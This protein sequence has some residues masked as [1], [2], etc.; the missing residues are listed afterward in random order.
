L[1]SLLFTLSL[2]IFGYDHYQHYF[3]NV[4][5]SVRI[6]DTARGF[7]SAGLFKR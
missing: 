4:V 7:V 6:D 1:L 5:G 2:L 3:V